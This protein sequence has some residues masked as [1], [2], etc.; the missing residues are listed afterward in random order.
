MTTDFKASQ[1]QTNRVI[2]TGS[3]A[4]GAAN[5][6]L[7]YSIEADSTETPNQG[8]I[9]SGVFDTSSGI[10]TDVFV[11]VSGGIAQKDV[12]GSYGVSVFGGDVHISGNLTVGGTGAAAAA[13]D[14]GN[15]WGSSF[16]DSIFSTGSVLI[17]SDDG[18]GT[19]RA[20]DYG[21][22]VFFYVSGALGGRGTGGV[23]VFG[24]DVVISGT[25]YA[26]RQVVEVD[27][28]TSSSLYVSGNLTVSESAEFKS[29]LIVTGAS[30]PTL[31]VD[32]DPAGPSVNIGALGTETQLLVNGMDLTQY[33]GSVVVPAGSL[34]DYTIL[35][36]GAHIGNNTYG[37]FNID[38][39]A[40]TLGSNLE[41]SSTGAWKFF[42]S[43]NKKTDGLRVVGV[44]QLENHSFIGTSSGDD[45]SLWGVDV[46]L[47]GTV[48]VNTKSYTS[49][50]DVSFGAVITKLSVL[51]TLGGHMLR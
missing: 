34:S 15:Y 33:S 49:L 45:P 17:R 32:P 16:T 29:E 28:F 36:L 30:A 8:Q 23:S 25:L 5:Q 47:G 1:V 37:M 9:N 7:V 42:I 12:G 35:D 39:F 46:T 44:T 27:E 41:A 50:Q 19:E 43:I 18:S 22:D 6:F 21:S 2:V 13:G 48:I 26:E 11:F 24:G 14:S 3:F 31:H 40:G 10:G 4:G 51:D 38:V 20:S